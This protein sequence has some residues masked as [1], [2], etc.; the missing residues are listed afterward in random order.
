M[1]TTDFKSFDGVRLSYRVEGEGRPILML[2]GFLANSHLNFIEPGITQAIV[3]AG[4]RA[5]MLDHRGHG[6]SDAPTEPSAYPLDVLSLDA[7]ALLRSLDITEYDIVGYSLGAR[8]AARMLVRGAK[9]GRAVIAGMGDN[10]VIGTQARVAFFEDAITNGEAG[11]FPQAAKVVRA[12]IE[13]AKVD[14]QAML[15]VLRSQR[16]TPADALAAIDTPILVVSGSEDNDNGSAEGLAALLPN[17]K[18]ARTPGNHL[19]AVNAPELA[20]AI[21]AF[22]SA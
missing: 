13:R 7:E 19:S 3:N 1:P 4:F 9:P 16:S 22:L 18:A 20:Q 14:P 6:L 17:A 5:I 8:T 2:H 11:A 21:V 10:G 12:L 15:Q